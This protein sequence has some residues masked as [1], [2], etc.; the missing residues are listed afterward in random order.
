MLEVFN[1]DKLCLPR[2]QVSAL[3]LKMR[4]P[5]VLRTVALSQ[6]SAVALHATLSVHD[7]RRQYRTVL[8]MRKCEIA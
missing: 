7:A 2:E 6:N 1:S 5:K 3:A 4:A 8:K